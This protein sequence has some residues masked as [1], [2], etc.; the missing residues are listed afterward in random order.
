MVDDLPDGPLDGPAGVQ[1]AVQPRE[2]G[3]PGGLLPSPPGWRP[4]AAR[5]R[6]L[7]ARGAAAVGHGGRVRSMSSAEVGCRPVHDPD[8]QRFRA[9]SSSSPTASGC[10]CGRSRSATPPV[11]S[12]PWPPLPGSCNRTME[13]FA[14]H[15]FGDDSP[16]DGL[17]PEQVTGGSCGPVLSTRP[18]VRI[19]KS[20][21]EQLRLNLSPGGGSRSWPSGL[22]T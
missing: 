20:S 3:A 13:D 18:E 7:R 11:G 2:R 1:L 14:R 15:P 4:P 10:A 5:D 8:E 22:E 12:T 17:R 19:P 9:T 21:T 6:G 16:H